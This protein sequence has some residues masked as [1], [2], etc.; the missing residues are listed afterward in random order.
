MDNNNPNGKR[1]ALSDITNEIDSKRWSKFS[2]DHWFPLEPIKEVHSVPP[3]PASYDMQNVH[4]VLPFYQ[5]DLVTTTM[6]HDELASLLQPEN[7]LKLLTFLQESG[8]IAKSQ[9]C[10]Y[11]G[12]MMKILQEDTY[13]YW[14]C[15]RRVNGKK[16]N[17]GRYSVRK[18]T[19]FDHSKLSIPTILWI[20]WHYVHHLSEKQ[21]REYT[22]I[23]QKNKKTI[24]HW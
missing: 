15:Y 6:S 8:I 10:K 9:Q 20:V 2:P 11:C 1:F 17:R 4:P 13:L 14:I 22:N 18:G 23:G 21:C 16:C 7:E 3:L 12:S 19:F 5:H 24:V